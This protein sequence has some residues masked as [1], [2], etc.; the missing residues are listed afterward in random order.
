MFTKEQLVLNVQCAVCS[1]V[2]SWWCFTPSQPVRSLQGT[3]SY[4]LPSQFRVHFFPLITQAKGKQPAWCLC[5]CWIT[6]G[7]FDNFCFISASQDH[8][9]FMSNQPELIS[10]SGGS[11]PPSPPVLRSQR[12][13]CNTW[14]Y[15]FTFPGC[16]AGITPGSR[17]K[18]K[19]LGRT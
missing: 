19:V 13:P 11:W 7:P 5:S 8:A 16:H 3:S 12:N 10:N 2:D 6:L 4:L 18:E 1:L 9:A 14:R 17:G 15:P